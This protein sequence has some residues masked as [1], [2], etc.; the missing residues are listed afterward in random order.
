MAEPWEFEVATFLGTMAQLDS[1]T[2]MWLTAVGTFVAGYLSATL[3]AKPKAPAAAPVPPPSA[4][5]PPPAEAQTPPII[6]D[7]SEGDESDDEDEGP[8]YKMVRQ[9]VLMIIIINK[10]DPRPSGVWIDTLVN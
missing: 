7:D 4:A 8:A 6:V 9:L 10:N 2:V 5:A 3:L 1:N